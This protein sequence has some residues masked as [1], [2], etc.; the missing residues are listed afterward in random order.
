[1]RKVKMVDMEQDAPLSIEDSIF[2][3]NEMDNFHEITGLPS[4]GLLYPNGTKILGRPL[5]VKEVKRLA[6][7]NEFN[8]HQ[9]IKD[10]IVNCTRG[11][12][13]EHILVPDKIYIIFWLRANTYKDAHFTTPYVCDHCGKESEYSFDV[14]DLEFEYLSDNFK[15]TDLTLTL[16]NGQ[17][18]TFKYLTIQDE[19]KITIFKNGMKNGITQYDD[20][21]IAIAAMIKTING[22]S[23]SL[24]SSCEFLNDIE[25]ASWAQ[26]NT[27][28]TK[29]DFGVKPVIDATCKHFDCREVSQVRVTFRPEFFIP[30]YTA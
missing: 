24:K 29:L 6:T 25:P 2:T 8:Y 19:E 3:K 23:P 12:K 1:M 18:I 17:I 7:M 13:V 15:D 27:F 30:N 4:K 28:V 16:V 20:L 22:Q 14:G 10:I 9:V 26:I 5:T 21:D 11:I